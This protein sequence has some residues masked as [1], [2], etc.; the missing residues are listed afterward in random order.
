MLIRSD[1]TY[2]NLIFCGP[3]RTEGKWCSEGSYGY[4]HPPLYVQSSKLTMDQSQR[5]VVVRGIGKFFMAR[6]QRIVLIF[7]Q[8]SLDALH[9]ALMAHVE[10]LNSLLEPSWPDAEKVHEDMYNMVDMLMIHVVDQK[11]F[12]AFA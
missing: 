8:D 5:V 10:K 7:T 3:E 12:S 11:W 1:L 9:T 6:G 4:I 2:L